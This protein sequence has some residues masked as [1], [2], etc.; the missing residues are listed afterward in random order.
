L[1]GKGART[2]FTGNAV[3]IVWRV[4]GQSA[5]PQLSDGIIKKN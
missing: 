4:A 1:P 2:P 3:K 5:R